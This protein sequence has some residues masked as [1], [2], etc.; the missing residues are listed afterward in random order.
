MQKATRNIPSLA[1]EHPGFP[2]RCYRILTMGCPL[3]LTALRGGVIVRRMTDKLCANCGEINSTASQFCSNCG[4]SE[5]NEVPPGLRDRPGDGTGSTRSSAVI[6][7]GNRVI[8]ASVLSG[9]LYLLYWFYITWKQLSLETENPHYP[10]W[11]ALTLLVPI[12]GL[13]RMHAHVRLINELAFRHR[14]AET[15]GPSLA[16]VLLVLSNVLNWASI[17]VTNYFATVLIAA[18]ST[19]L[20][21]MLMKMAQEVLNS[22]WEK[23]FQPESLRYARIGVGEVIIVAFGVLIWILIL[24]PRFVFEQAEAS[25]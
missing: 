21:T 9:G 5:F 1:I 4:F 6:I 24:I 13:F 18:I 3:K 25:F 12:F 23:A 7:S 8:L 16:V 14:I 2:I 10:V 19:A 15:F 20:V 22:Y 11:H 17:G